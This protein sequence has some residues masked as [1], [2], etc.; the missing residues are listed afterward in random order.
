M[1]SIILAVIL[2]SQLKL[3]AQENAYLSDFSVSHSN[4]N[5]I[6][7][8]TTSTD[9]VCEDV[10]VE[11]GLDTNKMA[12]VYTYPGICGV[13]GKEANYFFVFKSLIFNKINYFR[14][15]LGV[16]GNSTIAQTTI[17]KR[18]GLKPLVTPNPA[19][20]QSVINFSNNNRDVA[21]IQ[22]FHSN[23]TFTS[24]VIQTKENKIELASFTLNTSGLYY[25][26]VNIKGV[27]GYGRFFLQ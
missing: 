20:M 21:E 10:K 9:F 14:I 16:F 11:H 22:I 19:T 3:Y 8:W 12:I 5:V 17:I 6:I 25:F 23:G 1:R 27:I 2:F 13:E 4:D 15:N 7:S 18:T 26:S 24:S